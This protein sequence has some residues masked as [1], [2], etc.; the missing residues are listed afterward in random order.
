MDSSI[1]IVLLLQAVDRASAVMNS[2]FSNWNS[3]SSRA[4]QQAANDA[5]S[6]A[7]KIATAYGSIRL[8]QAGFSFLGDLVDAYGTQEE[9][10]NAFKSNLLNNGGIL[11]EN[12]WKKVQVLTNDLGNKLP[13]DTA[14]MYG[15]FNAL[16]EGGVAVT[17]ILNGT[18]EA[19]AHLAVVTRQTYDAA[20]KSAAVLQN[21]TGVAANDMNAFFD[22]LSRSS[23]LG[24]KMN[25]LED[26]FAN[27]AAGMKLL[28]IQGLEASQSMSAIFGVLDRNGLKGG[29]AGTN[30]GR[31]L[32]EISD[33]KKVAGMNAM[34][35][36]Y[37][38]ALSFFDKQGNF[39][40]PENMV[41]QFTKLQ[42]LN[43]IQLSKVLRPLTGGTG[44][45]DNI[46]KMLSMNGTG[47]VAAFMA[48]KAKQASMQLKLDQQLKGWKSQME[49]FEGTMTNLKATVGAS[50]VGMLNGLIPKIT[51]VVAKMQVFVEQH[52][53]LTKVAVAITAIASAGLILNGVITLIQLS[54]GGLGSLISLLANPWVAAIIL[55]AEAAL[56]IYR[57]WGAI[58]AW[59]SGVWKNLQVAAKNFFDFLKF[60]FDWSPIGLIVN[61]W[62][63][64]TAFFSGM[65]DGIKLLFKGWLHWMIYWPVELVQAGSNIVNSIWQGIKNKW[66]EFMAWWHEKIKVIREYLPFSPA[67]RGP[68]RDIHRIKLMETIA[69][70]IKP[71]PLLNAM[72]S[73]LNSMANMRPRNYGG[74][75]VGSNHFSIQVTLQGGATKADGAMVAET[76]EQTIRRVMKQDASNKQRV[77]FG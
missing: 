17:D 72:D 49:A 56:L 41:A 65:L 69:M 75:S 77:S 34:A 1:K 76:I 53:G 43:A 32:A 70:A 21:A 59:F 52:P 16:K 50:I 67:K 54:A 23:G 27:S 57:N 45:D 74:G 5:V 71:A 2:M 63:K 30:M 18:G 36:Q 10:A 38:V 12:Q 24:V 61:H 28:K 33:P 40:G 47:K 6:S 35:K 37:G 48:E 66:G 15:L 19:A 22:D 8:G 42:N 7:K 58:S 14:A 20:A 31:I 39:A 26:A 73:S 11:D 3:A 25:N 13:G 60:W 4:S 29:T 64:I 55:I 51:D 62:S 9:A 46:V 44:Q 68:L